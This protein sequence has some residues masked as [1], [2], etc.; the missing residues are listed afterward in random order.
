M[1]LVV[2]ACNDWNSLD[3]RTIPL[4]KGQVYYTSK[5]RLVMANQNGGWLLVNNQNGQKGYVPVNMLKLRS[6][7]NP[8]PQSIIP[9][10]SNITPT[11]NQHE[12]IP[13]Q[14]QPQFSTT[15]IQNVLNNSVA[16]PQ[17]LVNH[18]DFKKNDIDE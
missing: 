16:L 2:K 1:G 5:A 17:E 13:E 9:E 12:I 18:D 6:T 15:P 14:I 3:V 8:P 7:I 10:I 11:L 4:V